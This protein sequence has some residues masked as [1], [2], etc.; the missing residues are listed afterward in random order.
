M[1]RHVVLLTAM[2]LASPAMGFDDAS[3]AVIDASKIGKP[4]AIEDVGTLMMGAERW[5][6][7]QQDALCA[8]SDIY[9]SVD[10][11]GAS[12]EIS[13]PWSE[14]VD[15][16]FVATGDFRDGR[17]ICENGFDWVPSVRAYS[18][19]DGYALEGRELAALRDE[20]RTVV[21]TASQSA[22]Y[23]Y[24]YRGHDADNLTI[25]LLQRDYAG[26]D[27]EVLGEVLVTLHYDKAVADNLGWYW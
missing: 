20:I 27:D 24:I 5:C 14:T 22:C 8:W 15:I 2:L 3:Q 9:L 12:F 18:R 11:D 19:E 21:D 26:A 7:D 16:S 13:N 10:A 6:Y 23:D 1:K 17:Y 4:L 25:T